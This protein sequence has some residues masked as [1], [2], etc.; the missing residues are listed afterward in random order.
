MTNVPGA[1]LVVVLAA[2]VTALLL[3][4]VGIVAVVV[5]R[6]RP[7][8]GFQYVL[9]GSFV[10]VGVLGAAGVTV[11]F[12]PDASLIGGTLLLGAIV[13]LAGG[14]A[15]GIVLLGAA[16][17]I[18]AVVQTPLEGA[19]FDATVGWLIGSAVPIP[20]AFATGFL[21]LLVSPI[22][23]LLGALVGGLVVALVRGSSLEGVSIR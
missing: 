12:W 13:Y 14:I 22:A 3:V 6:L 8:V 20:L 9:A 17:A 2:G 19:L 1:G 11:S 4:A 16:L 21:L 18:R 10:G 7:D 15:A 5:G 23:G